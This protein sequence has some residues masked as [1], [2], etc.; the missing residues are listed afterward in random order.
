MRPPCK[1]KFFCRCGCV[2]IPR[3]R[4]GG[5]CFWCHHVY[6]RKK[7]SGKSEREHFMRW[8]PGCPKDMKKPYFW[9]RIS[10]GVR[11]ENELRASLESLSREE[12]KQ[13]SETSS[14]TAMDSNAQGT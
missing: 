13:E 8:C 12:E 14:S 2:D 9:A 11:S 1:C 3:Q 7:Y 6:E 5:L 4:V 10:G